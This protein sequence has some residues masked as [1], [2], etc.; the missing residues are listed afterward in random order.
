[1]RICVELT[2]RI[3]SKRVQVRDRSDVSSAVAKVI[4]QRLICFRRAK[5]GTTT[6]VYDCLVEAGRI[7]KGDP[8]R[9]IRAVVTFLH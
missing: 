1:M 3:N 9:G 7:S 8:F 6:E 2:D 4:G 5:T